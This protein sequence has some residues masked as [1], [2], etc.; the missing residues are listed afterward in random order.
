V[1][2]VATIVAGSRVLS[3]ALWWS[4]GKFLDR[5]RHRRSKRSLINVEER[6]TEQTHLAWR[7]SAHERAVSA[8][9]AECLGACQ[10]DTASGCGSDLDDQTNA[11]SVFGPPIEVVCTELNVG[12]PFFRI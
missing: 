6:R 7:G 11:P 10:K 9:R 4:E 12:D 3:I 1:V 5:F 8:H 2:R